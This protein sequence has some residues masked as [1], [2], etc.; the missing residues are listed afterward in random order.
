[1]F[2]IRAGR[3]SQVLRMTIA[4]LLLFSCARV[5][6]PLASTTAST[7]AEVA[8]RWLHITRN[9]VFEVG[10]GGTK[11]TRPAISQP[12]EILVARASTRISSQTDQARPF[13]G[14]WPELRRSF[15]HRL[16][17]SASDA[18]H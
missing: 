1:M 6:R 17:P 16:L 14:V 4:A 9:V 8:V 3:A 13:V 11:L 10:A 5:I 18:G 7:S 12:R 2:A 15:L